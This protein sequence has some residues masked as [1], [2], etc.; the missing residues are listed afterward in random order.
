MPNLREWNSKPIKGYNLA[1]YWGR[2]TASP[3]DAWSNYWSGASVFAEYYVKFEIKKVRQN[4]FPQVAGQA[5]TDQYY[6]PWV[7]GTSCRPYYPYYKDTDLTGRTLAPDL[8]ECNHKPLEGCNLAPFGG[9]M[10][11][12]KC[13]L[14]PFRGKQPRAMLT[15]KSNNNSFCK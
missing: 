15:L 8:R 14:S 7:T 13:N 2:I 3:V 5:V 1:P 12:L 10:N 11:H 9:R 4:N 6:G